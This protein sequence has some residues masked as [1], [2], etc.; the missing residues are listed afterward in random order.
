MRRKL[1]NK[2]SVIL[3]VIIGFFTIFSYMFDQLVIREE[4]NYRITQIKFEN[5]NTK[6]TKL[7]SISTQ[8][9]TSYDSSVAL[10]I[11]LKRFKNYWLKSILLIT[12]YDELGSNLNDQDIIKTFN[13]SPEYLDDLVKSRNIDHFKQVVFAINE[14]VE[15]LYNIYGWNLNFFPQYEDGDHYNGPDIEYSKIFDQNKDIFYEKNFN[16]YADLVI[17][18]KKI[19]DAVKNFKIK[20]WI[21]LNKYYSLLLNRLDELNYIPLNDSYFVDDLISK[22]EKIRYQIMDDLRKISSKKNYYILSSIISQIASLLFLLI[23]FRNLINK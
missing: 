6:L 12:N 17:D 20:N 19:D 8:L 14:Q 5:L 18:T 23:L 7:N 3:I 4:D 22:N 9:T 15:R 11:N 13:D 1:S 10:T 21:D 16:T 2:T